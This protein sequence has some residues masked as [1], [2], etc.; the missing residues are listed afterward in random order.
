M[1]RRKGVRTVLILVSVLVGCVLVLSGLLLLMSPGKPKPFVDAKGRPIAGSISEK[2]YVDVNGVRQGMFIK[3]RDT[4]NPVLLYLHGGIPDY[5]LTQHYPTGLDEIFTVCWWDQRGAGLSFGADPTL[6]SVSSEQLIS[7]TLA[8]TDYL[9]ERFGKQ[10]IYLMAHSGGTFFGIQAAARSPERFHAYIGVAQMADQLA[11]ER[12]A[13]DYM[14]AEYIL[15]SNRDMIERFE[16][17]RIS[18]EGDIPRAYLALRDPCM[19]S[20]GV[21]TMH[22]MKSIVTGLFIPS[23]TFRDYTIRDKIDLWKGKAAAGTSAIWEEAIRTDLSRKIV[24]VDLP[25]YFLHGIYDY[26]CSY[27]VARDFYA[28]LDAPV[29]GFYSFMHSSHS[30]LFEEPAK[31]QQIMREDVLAGTSTLSDRT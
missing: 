27:T 22:T 5:F 7:D 20:L 1:K 15:A 30:P 26:T 17:A 19:H 16:A 8:L 23:L 4:K 18:D 3:G 14:M 12:Q 24:R 11:S 6:A 28:D 29:K 25:V 2:R 21:G 10:K 31:L 13:Y 9:R